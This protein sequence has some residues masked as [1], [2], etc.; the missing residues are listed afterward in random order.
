ML[1]LV[2]DLQEQSPRFCIRIGH[3][4]ASHAAKRRNATTWVAVMPS[5]GIAAVIKKLQTKP[6]G[7]TVSWAQM[8]VS[9][10]KYNKQNAHSSGWNAP[11]EKVHAVPGPYGFSKHMVRFSRQCQADFTC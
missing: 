11:H 3:T 1:G 8:L 10:N 5:D 2:L 4:Q 6:V 9:S 7:G